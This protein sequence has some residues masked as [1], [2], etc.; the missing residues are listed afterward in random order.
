[1][2][3][4]VARRAGVMIRCGAGVRVNVGGIVIVGDMGSSEREEELKEGGEG[5]R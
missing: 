4:I 1:M 2:W 3:D 5:L